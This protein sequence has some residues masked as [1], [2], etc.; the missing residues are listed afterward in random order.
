LFIFS[1]KPENA[2]HKLSAKKKPTGLGGRFGFGFLRGFSSRTA[3]APGSI[4]SG[5]MMA[6]AGCFFHPTHCFPF[7][8]WG[9][10]IRTFGILVNS[11]AHCQLC[12]A[13]MVFEKSG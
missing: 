12:Y 11:Q 1:S 2:F 7:V 3:A 5:V 8:C 4:V 13:P 6:V 10:R 9:G